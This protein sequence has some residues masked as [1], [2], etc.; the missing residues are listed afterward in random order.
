WHAQGA[1][2]SSRR[3]TDG[4]ASAPRET[5]ERARNGSRGAPAQRR[6]PA[7]QLGWLERARLARRVRRVRKQHESQLLDLGGLI[8]DMYRF[9]STRQ[10]LVREKLK[11]LFTGTGELRELEAQLGE[12]LRLRERKAEPGSGFR[13]M[14]LPAAIATI[15][16]LA[17]AWLLG[18]IRT[19]R[20]HDTPAVQRFTNAQLQAAF[21]RQYRSVAASVHGRR[22]AVY[23]SPRSSHPVKTLRNPNADG[24]PLV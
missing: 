9:G 22:I 5:H 21:A 16:I 13:W 4:A 6:G 8:F 3:T 15:V 19:Q 11:L 17:A 18:G 12:E 10:D 20:E 14:S 24:A 2:A 23:R 1:A 7:K